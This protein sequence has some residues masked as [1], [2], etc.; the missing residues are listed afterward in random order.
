MTP[1]QELFWNAL[2]CDAKWFAHQHI[3]SFAKLSDED[4]HVA[5]DQ[6]MAQMH[7][8]L[9]AE[10]ISSVIKTWLSTYDLPLDARKL[11]PGFELV[12]QKINA[13]IMSDFKQIQVVEPV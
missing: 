4:L 8:S 13:Y 11:G 7:D 12:H 5:I 6:L 1:E 2:K 3:Q 10:D 9:T